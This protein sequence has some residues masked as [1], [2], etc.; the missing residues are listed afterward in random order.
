M[1]DEEGEFI[2]HLN[3]SQKKWE[4]NG[5]LWQGKMKATWSNHT[6][7]LEAKVK[8]RVRN[9]DSVLEH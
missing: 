9:G 2:T 4:R 8:Q 1:H 7:T 6:T 5:K 3:K